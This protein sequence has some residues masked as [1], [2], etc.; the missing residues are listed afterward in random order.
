MC[1]I[2]D[3][4]FISNLPSPIIDFSILPDNQRLFDQLDDPIVFVD[5][6]NGIWQDIVQWIW[7]YDNGSFGSD[8]ISYHSFSDTGTYVIM[9]TTVSEYNCID[10]MTKILT[11]TDYNLYIPNAFT[12]FSTNDEL[13]EIFKA[14]GI[15]ITDFKMEIYDRWGGRLFTSNSLDIGWDG[16][17]K[18][19]NQVPVGIYIYLIEAVNIYGENFKYHGQVKLIR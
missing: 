1:Q 10:T 18:N 3:T 12:P 16:T 4:V 14:Y 11:I 8:S 9:L 5:Y 6:T 19:G 17:T 7:D 13:N 15:G 2:Y